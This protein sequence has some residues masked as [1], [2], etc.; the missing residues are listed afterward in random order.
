MLLPLIISFM[1]LWYERVHTK[2][3][4]LELPETEKKLCYI[5]QHLKNVK[6]Q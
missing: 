5:I 2:E 3:S 6:E 4:T 1:A